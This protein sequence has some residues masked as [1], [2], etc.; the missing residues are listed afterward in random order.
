MNIRLFD[1]YVF[2]ELLHLAN[3]NIIDDDSKGDL[4]NAHSIQG[5]INSGIAGNTFY[6]HAKREAAKKCPC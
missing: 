4:Y 3:A 5:M 6:A 2:H 1:S